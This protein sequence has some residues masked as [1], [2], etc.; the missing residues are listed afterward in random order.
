MFI[1]IV[2]MKFKAEHCAAFEANFDRNKEKIRSFPGCRR[3]ELLHDKNDPTIYFTY[4]YWDDDSDLEN[5][6]NSDLF[7]GVWTYTKSL[8]DAKAEAW[9]VE[10]RDVLV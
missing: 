9:S 8:F 2:K 4:S 3:L 5:Y 7:K 1:R 6:R 10:Q